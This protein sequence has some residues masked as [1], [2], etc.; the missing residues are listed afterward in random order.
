MRKLIEQVAKFGVVGIIA[1]LID[2]GVMNLLLHFHINN[3]AAS[4]ASFLISL[5]F[6]YLASM[7]YVFTHRDDMA[8]WMEIL[9]FFVSAAIG[10][11]INELIIWAG[12]STL[13]A[14]A[15]TA[16]HAKYVLY[17]NASKIVATVVVSIWNFII[18]KWLL[19]APASGRPKAKDSLACRLGA[20]SLT[21]RPF[22]WR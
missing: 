9:V 4:T 18:R 22:G 15:A 5:A 20:F 16:M 6:N 11:G 14:D 17:T 13:P 8:R 10:L 1:F 2:I 7:K 3:L 12:T 21:H 19:D